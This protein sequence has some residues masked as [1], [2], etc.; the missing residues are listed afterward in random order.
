[1]VLKFGND[2]IR[3]REMGLNM[4]QHIM[5]YYAWVIDYCYQFMNVYEAF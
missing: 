1:M 4:F 2:L 5:P 3:G